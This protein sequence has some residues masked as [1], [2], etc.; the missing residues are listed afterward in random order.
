M[1]ETVE[2]LFHPTGHH[3]TAWDREQEKKR[4]EAEIRD[5]L[6][7]RKAEDDAD[8]QQL[9]QAVSELEQ[10][11][12][13]ICKLHPPWTMAA[14]K[15]ITTEGGRS[16]GRWE[17]TQPTAVGHVP[18]KPKY[19]VCGPTQP[20]TEWTFPFGSCI[21]DLLQHSCARPKSERR[22][23]VPKARVLEVAEISFPAKRGEIRRF[24]AGEHSIQK[25]EGRRVNSSSFMEVTLSSKMERWGNQNR[26]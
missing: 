25:V 11:L 7:L 13:R 14:A 5:S 19:E 22:L 4:L 1:K 6:F 15:A 9:E 8:L 21:E 3:I 20:N 26:G 16:G 24:E 2:Q 23:W 12:G 17:T 10:A 18:M